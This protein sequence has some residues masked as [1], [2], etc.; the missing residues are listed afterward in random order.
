MLPPFLIVFDIETIPDENLAVQVLGEDGDTFEDVL[1]K[2][3]QKY[4]KDS[5]ED[6][7][8]PPAF[9]QITCIAYLARLTN[10]DGTVERHLGAFSPQIGEEGILK[11]FW[12]TMGRLILKAQ[13][14]SDSLPPEERPVIPSIITYNGKLFDIPAILARTLK[15]RDV[16]LEAKMEDKN[17]ARGLSV[18][19]DD[20]DRW[21]REKANYTHPYSRYN[22]DLIEMLGGRSKHTLYAMCS[23]C[24]IPVK[25]EGKGNEVLSY[26]KNGEFEKIARYCAEDVKATYM[27]YLNYLLLK[28]DVQK[29]QTIREEM[30][31]VKALELKIIA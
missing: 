9:H 7:F 20:G 18:F 22:I 21:E 6:V 5:I 26:Y 12:K 8:L 31:S 10:P 25:T 13:Q 3:R 16:F 27:L 24:N 15:Y 1:E 14:F 2:R 19:L 28:A 11:A 30:E 17:V 29:M 23:L 4:K